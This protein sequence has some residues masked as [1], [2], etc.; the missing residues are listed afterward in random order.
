VIYPGNTKA[1]STGSKM[2][3][4]FFYAAKRWGLMVMAALALHGVDN[5]LDDNVGHP[6]TDNA[7]RVPKATVKNIVPHI[8]YPLKAEW[9]H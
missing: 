2:E 5:R 3:N 1:F 4:A 9:K 6:H 7:Q 8:P